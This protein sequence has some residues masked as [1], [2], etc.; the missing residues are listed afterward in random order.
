MTHAGPARLIGRRILQRL[1]LFP[2]PLAP[3]A[4]LLP[5]RLPPLLA[6]AVLL[7][8]LPLRPPPCRVTAR[9]A[10]IVPPSTA[11]TKST[12]APLQQ[13]DPPARATEGSLHSRST[14]IMLNEAHGRLRLPKAQAS[15]GSYLLSSEAILSALPVRR[16]HARRHPSTLLPLPYRVTSHRAARRPSPM[17][18]DSRPHPSATATKVAEI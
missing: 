9:L 13:T 1:A 17:T 2:T 16:G 15:D 18:T 8:G 6:A 14:R 11:G 12:P 4:A 3:A 5:P 10:A 7:L